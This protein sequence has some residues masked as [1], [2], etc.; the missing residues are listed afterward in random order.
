M[1]HG[2]QKA[3]TSTGETYFINHN[4][5][6]TCWEDPRIALIPSYLKQQQQQMEQPQ[7][8]QGELFQMR[9]EH[10][11]SI[12]SENEF[13]SCSFQGFDSSLNTNAANLMH[14]SSSNNSPFPALSDSNVCSMMDENM[15]NTQIKNLIVDII[16]KRKELLKSLEELNKKVR[17]FFYLFMLF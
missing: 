1:P 10:Q 9:H 5:K 13:Q 7:Q 11:D 14:A 4:T 15:N 8:Q 16:N 2:W 17:I 3:Q 12:S 6:T